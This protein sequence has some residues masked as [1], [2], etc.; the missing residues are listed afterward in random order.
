VDQFRGC[1]S[2]IIFGDVHVVSQVIPRGND[3][4]HIVQHVNFQNVEGEGVSTGNEYVMQ[5]A[6]S[7]TSN[8][9]TD[10]TGST[11]DVSAVN[12]V[13]K[14]PAKSPNFFVHAIFHITVNANGEITSEIVDLDA[15]CRG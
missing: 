6:F 10:A 3:V 2:D 5:N 7:S 15:A 14:G 12:L 9:D 8:F 11:T 13:S 4:F 1:T